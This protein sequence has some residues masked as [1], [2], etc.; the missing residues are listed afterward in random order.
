MHNQDITICFT[1]EMQELLNK[2]LNDGL[3]YREGAFML[4]EIQ[5]HIEHKHPRG[6]VTLSLPVS[7]IVVT[8]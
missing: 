8:S 1:H 3:T 6:P 7:V 2:A 4:Q 5:K